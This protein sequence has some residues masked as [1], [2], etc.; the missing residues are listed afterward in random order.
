MWSPSV[1]PLC[2]TRVMR[3]PLFALLAPFDE[4]SDVADGA[5]FGRSP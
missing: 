1:G 2:K 5:L 4:I 3:R